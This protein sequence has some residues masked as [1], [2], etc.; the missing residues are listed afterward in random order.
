MKK[1]LSFTRKLQKE[2][3]TEWHLLK[4]LCPRIRGSGH[5]MRNT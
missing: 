4:H 5:E 1:R 2:A 3:S